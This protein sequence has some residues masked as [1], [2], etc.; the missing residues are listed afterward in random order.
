[1][2][3]TISVK[4]KRRKKKIY[5]L[6]ERQ[7]DFLKDWKVVRYYIQKKYEITL[8]ELEI[9]LHLYSC[10]PFTRDYFFQYANLSDWDKGKLKKMMD[11]G[12]IYIYRKKQGRE[13]KLYDLTHQAK[14]ICNLTYKKLTKKEPIS[15]NPR[16]NPMFSKDASFTDKIYKRI[17]EKMNRKLNDPQDNDQ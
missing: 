11:R 17:I 12:F 10:G 14:Y 13:S 16:S 5:Q 15:E 3:K 2:I 8:G 6:N 7:E 1:M 4:K 9:L